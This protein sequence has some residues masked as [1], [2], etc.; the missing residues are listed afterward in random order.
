MVSAYVPSTI[1]RCPYTAATA[2]PVRCLQCVP[3]RRKP[4]V[5][6]L[7]GT[8]DRSAQKAKQELLSWISGTGRGS[9]TTKQLRGQIEEAQVSEVQ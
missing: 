5:A 3:R 9:K 2:P 4:T 8:A 7:A 6:A 1:K